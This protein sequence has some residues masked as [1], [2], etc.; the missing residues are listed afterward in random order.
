MPTPDLPTTQIGDSVEQLW[1]LSLQVAGCRQCGQAFLIEANRLGQPCPNCA[2]GKLE[3]QPARLSSQ[4]PELVVP[5]AKTQADVRAV[6]ENFVKGVWLAPDD[7]NTEMLL[8][9]AV[10]VFWPM[11]LV[12]GDVAGNWQAEAGFDYQ[13]KSSQESYSNSGWRSREVIETRQRWEPRTGQI[14]RHYDNICVPAASDHARLIGL[15]GDYHLD[16]TAA[17]DKASVN[18]STMRLPDLPPQSAWPQAQVGLNH[19][20]EQEC[21]KA[22]AAQHIRNYSVNA[23][24]NSLN[25]TQMLLPLVVSYYTDDDGKTHPVYINGQS[26]TI[27]GVRMASQRKGWL[28][29][30]ILAG[31]A[32]VLL[33]LGLLLSV[34]G[35][36][37]VGGFLIFVAILIAITA[38][39][40][41]AW[42][43]Q[44]NRRQRPE[45]VVSK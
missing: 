5:F 43:W 41:A 39:V 22:A 44:W 31:I 28:W 38:L 30:G 1:G 11:W 35:L 2:C 34:F 21:L 26:G 42:P 36:I 3:S 23:D 37:P 7:F 6:L 12:D 4:P 13:V 16:R 24:Y 45:N 20:A 33:L 8:R 29:A 40:P 17:Y 32:L 18:R 25:W 10:A 19:A 15:V 9:R 14:L 27:G